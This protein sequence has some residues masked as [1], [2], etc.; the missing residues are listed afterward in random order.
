[1]IL[2]AKNRLFNYKMIVKIEAI[3]LLSKLL[4]G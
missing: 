4:H 3:S 1:M 2:I